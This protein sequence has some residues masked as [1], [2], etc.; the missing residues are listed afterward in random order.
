[1]KITLPTGPSLVIDETTIAKEAGQFDA[2]TS[3]ASKLITRM[4]Q[5]AYR[6]KKLPL[7][8][9]A[10]SLLAARAASEGGYKSY[11]EPLAGVGLS[12]KLFNP[13]GSVTLN[14]LD[15]GCQAVLKANFPQAAVWGKDATTGFFPTADLIFLD[16]NNFT[17]KR[18]LSGDKYYVDMMDRAFSSARK[19]VILND[20]SV[21]YF[22]YGEGSYETY[23]RLRGLPIHTTEEYLKSLPSLY[24]SRYDGWEL[25]HAAY[26]SESSFQLFK[27]GRKAELIV[28]KA[29]PLE[30]KIGE[31]LLL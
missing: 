13:K 11:F 28:E 20:C 22:R 6:T 31:G 7:K 21:F 24:S 16:F 23:S 12:A 4:G 26:F 27:R 14:D 5:H 17:L 9:G 30:L 8:L 1:M 15:L 10:L 2:S 18:Y 19:F 25:I 29:V 3:Y